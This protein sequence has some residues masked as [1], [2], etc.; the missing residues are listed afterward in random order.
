MNLPSS[1]DSSVRA[2]QQQHN[3]RNST[4]NDHS[5]NRCSSEETVKLDANFSPSNDPT[6][7]QLSN[8]AT[9]IQELQT[10][11]DVGN[12][13]VH[14]VFSSEDSSTG[15]LSQ[16]GRGPLLTSDDSIV[17]EWQANKIPANAAGALADAK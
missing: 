10:Q 14:N 12:V 11:Q 9:F 3:G 2:E 16:N 1:G 13:S 8:D 4:R 5:V 7:Y 15:A 17:I 6:G